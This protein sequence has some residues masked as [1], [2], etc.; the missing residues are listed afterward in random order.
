MIIPKALA[1]S[2]DSSELH[3]AI[4][5]RK[6]RQIGDNIQRDTPSA[7]FGETSFAKSIKVVASCCDTV[8]SASCG[9]PFG[10]S[11]VFSKEAVL[12]LSGMYP[13]VRSSVSSFN[14]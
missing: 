14:K 5:L 2:S 7:I 3:S 11:D 1:T 4:P 8:L 10:V 12:S 13:S 9:E 6:S